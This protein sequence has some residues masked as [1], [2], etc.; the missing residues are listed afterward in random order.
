MTVR[1]EYLRMSFE[2]EIKS[3][4]ADRIVGVVTYFAILRSIFDSLGSNTKDEHQSYDQQAS[5]KHAE[6]TFSS[7]Q[8]DYVTGMGTV[9]DICMMFK[10]S[11]SNAKF[12]QRIKKTVR[13]Y[14]A[15]KLIPPTAINTYGGSF[16]DDSRDEID[17][18]AFTN[19]AVRDPNLNSL[20]PKESLSRI[21]EYMRAFGLNKCDK[22]DF[23][24]F[25]EVLRSR[26]GKTIDEENLT[27]EDIYKKILEQ[28]EH[29]KDVSENKKK[30]Y[31]IFCGD[32]HSFP[33]S[34]KQI[35]QSIIPMLKGSERLYRGM[36][37]LETCKSIAK[38][39]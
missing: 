30:V 6:T 2:E 27:D 11:P 20:L 23:M 9:N 29:T 13:F 4:I 33:A 16:G 3:K 8:N 7:F 15:R 37:I 25:A 35:Q 31:H 14:I 21:E 34:K 38:Q 26:F 1:E 5:N 22:T 28:K 19:V 10:S 32:N 39:Q 17:M 24:R 36:K 18:I 12:V